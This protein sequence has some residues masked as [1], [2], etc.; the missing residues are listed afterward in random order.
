MPEP[1]GLYNEFLNF[2]CIWTHDPMAAKH[3]NPGEIVDLKTWTSDP[4]ELRTQAL[5]KQKR[6][7]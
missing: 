2:D 5:V 3:A 1:L 6:W 4:R 7:N